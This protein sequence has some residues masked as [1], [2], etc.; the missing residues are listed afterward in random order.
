MQLTQ[1]NTGSH[2][3]TVADGSGRRR[4][5]G[6]AS[7]GGFSTARA[8]ETWKGR[9]EHPVRNEIRRAQRTGREV[10]MLDE[11]YAF[12]A[13]PAGK[14]SRKTITCHIPGPRNVLCTAHHVRR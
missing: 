9:V 1:V 6:G 14:P 13:E 7:N 3:N 5:P 2:Q 12:R 10:S 4:M 11:Q 8:K